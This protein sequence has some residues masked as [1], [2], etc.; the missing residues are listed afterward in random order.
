M[1]D[2]GFFGEL[3]STNGPVIKR[4]DLQFIPGGADVFSDYQF[5]DTLITGRPYNMAAF[6]KL[7]SDSQQFLGLSSLF[8]MEPIQVLL[9]STTPSVRFVIV[10]E[11]AML[12]WLGPAIMVAVSGRRRRFWAA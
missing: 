11:P 3:Q 6:Y 5:S 1:S 9:S 7:E 2:L 12:F 10:L 4:E 8:A